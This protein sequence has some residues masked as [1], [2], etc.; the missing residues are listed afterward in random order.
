M[1][2]LIRSAIIIDKKSE[3]HNDRV[4][5]LIKNGIISNIAPS[6]KN[7]NNYKELKLD[8][9][10]VSNGWFDYSISCGQPGF[11][12]RDNMINTLEVASKSGFTCLGIQPNTYP[13]IDKRSEIEYIKLLSSNNIVKVHPIGSLTKKSEGNELSEIF[14]MGDGGAIAFGDYKRSIK[15][16]NILKLALQYS[17]NSNYP[18]MSFPNTMDISEN[19]VVNENITSTVLGLNPIPSFS[20]HLNVQRDLTILEYAGGKLHIPTIST[21]KSAELIRNAKKN[22]L[23]VTCS[24]TIHNLFFDDQNLN[25]YNTNF[26]VLPPLRSTADIE[27]LKLAVKDGTIDLVT[28]DHNPLNIEL[29]DLEFE[30]AAFGTIGLES[31]FGALNK[32]FSTKLA[33]QILTRGRSKF[34]LSSTTVSIGELADITLF[35]PN[36]DYIFSASQILSKSKN[37]IFINSKLKGKVYGIISNNKLKLNV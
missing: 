37:S 32:L 20:E 29:K 5:I 24:T 4:D 2:L 14:D 11:E 31:C 10:H 13:V 35:N 27:S 30:N 12:E 19:G 21:A 9:L 34:S 28:C 16:P 1:N 22:G 36:N 26:K 18:I 3:F 6:I 23:N 33:I 8:N 7:S 15:N 25:G 17:N